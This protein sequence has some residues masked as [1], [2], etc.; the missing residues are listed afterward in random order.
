MRDRSREFMQK[1]CNVFIINVIFF[2]K[3]VDTNSNFGNSVMCGNDTA[4]G[5]V[6]VSGCPKTSRIQGREGSH[7]EFFLGHC[8]D[9]YTCASEQQF[10]SKRVVMGFETICGCFCRT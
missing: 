9:F 8:C 4:H 6:I 5:V 1:F 10:Y 3:V 2:K 7:P